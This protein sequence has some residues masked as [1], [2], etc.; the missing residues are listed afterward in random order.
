MEIAPSVRKRVK[1]A[2]ERLDQLESDVPRL[3]AGVNNG[4]SNLEGRLN[5]FTEILNALSQLTGETAVSAKIAENRIARAE[6]L[7]QQ[8]EE[9]LKKAITDGRVVAVAAVTEQSVIVGSKSDKDGKLEVA[10]GR[11]QM[12]FAQIIPA[13]KSKFL[14]AVVG[15]KVETPDGGTIEV[16]EIYDLVPQK[17]APPADAAPADI[18]TDAAAAA[19]ATT[20]AP[21]AAPAVDASTT[22]AP[23]GSTPAQ[24]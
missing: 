11:V 1:S 2:L 3:I 7:A 5:E 10:N 15:A 14:G 21:A 17:E 8:Q 6:A 19:P 23:A 18:A 9:G 16:K 12:E 4:F 13:F 22:P 20:A 24:A